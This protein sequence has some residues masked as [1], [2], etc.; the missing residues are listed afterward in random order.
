MAEQKKKKKKQVVE[1]TP[2]EKFVQLQTLKRATVCMLVE[3]DIYDIYVKLTKD[4]ASLGKLGEEKPFEG[5]EQCVSLSE[6]CAALADEWKQKIPAERVVES[7]TVTTTAKERE[8]VTQKKGKGKWVAIVVLILII[9]LIAAYQIP[10]TRYYIAALENVAGF[11]ELAVQTY[12]KLGQYKDS[13]EKILAIEKE[14][15]ANTKKGNKVSFGNTE[16]RVIKKEEDKV[17]LAADTAL[18]DVVYHE[19]EGNVTWETSTLRQY[20]NHTFMDKTFSEKEKEAV[21]ITKL[22]NEDNTQY[23]TAGGRDTEDKVFILS[24]TELKQYRKALKDKVASI[25]LRTP[26][27]KG[28]TT[29]FVSYRNKPV[30]FGVPTD[31]RAATVRPMIWV[32]IE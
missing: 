9:A 15:I 19:K 20:L 3:Q 2:A 21:L 27:V 23:G 7:R 13:E 16:W 1:L 5:W 28:S 14:V 26:G 29:M 4:F 11:D 30:S 8:N 17:L 24:E 32:A 6:E 18:T 22:K 10:V 25:R 31:E 12:E